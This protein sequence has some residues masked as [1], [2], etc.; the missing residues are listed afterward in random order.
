MVILHN[1]HTYRAISLFE[2]IT[3]KGI[4]T[5]SLN[6]LQYPQLDSKRCFNNMNHTHSFIPRTLK[7]Q[8][9]GCFLGVGRLPPE[10]EK[11]PGDDS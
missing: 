2:V 8:A 1:S 9:L 4:A 7:Y 3:L 11:I 6:L 5:F 10:K